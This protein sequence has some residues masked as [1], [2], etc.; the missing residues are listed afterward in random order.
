LARGE[1]M[2][3]LHGVPITIKDTLE[4]IGVIRTGGTRAARISFQGRR[5][6]GGPASPR[7]AS[8]LARPMP[9]LAGAIE[10]DNPSTDAPTIP[11]IS[12]DTK[13]AGGE[14]AI[15][16]ACGSPLGS[17]PTPRHSNSAHFAASPRSNRPAASRAPAN[18]QCRW[19]RNPV[20]HVSLIARKVDDLT[21]ALP[22]IAG[23]D[24]RDHWIVG[25]P[26]L[27]QRP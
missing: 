17:A 12:H 20:F 11:M 21:L 9:E 27:D 14:S 13:A 5:D 23:P 3:P 22:I 10:T 8:S 26:L 7:A 1:I 4:S 15:V 6:R 25:M 24:F 16:A 2:G 18:S 19:V